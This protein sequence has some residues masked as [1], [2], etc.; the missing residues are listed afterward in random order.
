MDVTGITMNVPLASL[1]VHLDGSLRPQTMVDLANEH[2]VRLPA[3]DAAG[4]ETTVFR[5]SYR[6]LD[7]YLAGFGLTC[8]VMAGPQAVRRVAR[9]LVEDAAG[10]GVRYLE[11]RMAPQLLER[12]GFSTVEVLS[13]MVDG[14]AEASRSLNVGLGPGRAPYRQAI[15]ACAMRAVVPGMGWRFRQLFDTGLDAVGVAV[16]AAQLLLADVLDAREA[17]VPVAGMDLA[18]S[19]VAGPARLFAPVFAAAASRGLGITIHA[20]EARGA[21][22]IHEAVSLLGASRIGH[23]TALFR[24]ELDRPDDSQVDR[25]WLA[26]LL[27]ERR[28]GLE[29]CLKS[30]CD[31]QA[32]P[33]LSA[34]PLRRMIDHGLAVCLDTDNR[35]VSH[36]TIQ[37]EF[38]RA[39]EL[40]LTMAE[41]RDIALN[42][43]RLAFFPGTTAEHRDYCTLVEREARGALTLTWPVQ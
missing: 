5:P 25:P 10:E 33:A 7:E 18:G 31:T 39:L 42:S 27:K 28:I 20:G 21:A 16:Q 38:R 1:H 37:D 34:H 6:S 12:P 29:V 40:G 14:M 36:T 22:S 23:G 4:L 24:P 26:G 11:V 15:I 17:G 41:C 19:E 30:N 35:L 32:I 2:A 13:A 9:E 8:A 43:F 3:P